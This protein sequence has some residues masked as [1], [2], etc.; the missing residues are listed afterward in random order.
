MDLNLSGSATL[1]IYGNVFVESS[2]KLRF[3]KATL[4]QWQSYWRV[5]AVVRVRGRYAREAAEYF[6]ESPGIEIRVGSS[7]RNWK[8]QAFIDV[9]GLVTDYIF[10]Y[11]EDHL[12]HPNAPSAERLTKALYDS[13]ADILQYSWFFSYEELRYQMSRDGNIHDELVVV[14][15]IDRDYQRSVVRP[16][17]VY[18]VGL[19]SVFRR[20]FL[21]KILETGRPFL[22]RFDPA[23]PFDVEQSYTASWFLPISLAFPLVEVGVCIDD[24]HSVPGSSAISRGYFRAQAETREF[25]HRPKNSLTSKLRDFSQRSKVLWV[26]QGLMKVLSGLDY[27]I[28]SVQ[29]PVRRL[30]DFRDIRR[31]LQTNARGNQTLEG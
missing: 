22:R 25:F 23:G 17:R 2:S 10:L 27:L 21:L 12:L 3:L 4:P 24:D 13:D 8:S 7:L 28:F 18:S 29:A 20:T 9:L 16:A 19:S 26:K 6:S 5:P 31:S 14:R 15:E 1:Q 11:Q 30:F